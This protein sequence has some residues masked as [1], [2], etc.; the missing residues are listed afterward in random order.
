MPPE[1]AIRWSVAPHASSHHATERT[2]AGHHAGHPATGS[3]T[4]PEA[5]RQA[6]VESS[7]QTGSHARWL[8]PSTGGIRVITVPMAGIQHQRKQQAYGRDNLTGGDHS[9]STVV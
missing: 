6:T 8:L 3:E 5:F 2:A 7:P 9:G 4:A 1:P